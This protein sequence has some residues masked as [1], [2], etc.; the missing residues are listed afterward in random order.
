MRTRKSLLNFATGL[1]GQML[2]LAASLVQRIV[3]T[4]LMSASYLGL[5]GLFSG[6][7]SVLSLAEL[8]VGPAITFSLY[9]PLAQGDTQTVKSLMRLYRRAYRLI[10]CVILALGFL[11]T[12]VYPHLIRDPGTIP[13]LTLIYWLYVVNTGISYFFSYKISLI[14]ADQNQYIRN[15]GHYAAYVLLNLS[16]TV[17]L[18]VTRS[19]VLFLL[20]QIVFTL[21]ENLLLSR[22]ADRRYPY[23]RD[24]DVR[25]L[26]REETAPIVRNIRA[27]LCHNVGNMVVNSTD[28]ILIARILGLA[29]SGVYSNYALILTA[30]RNVLARV[31]DAVQASVGNVWAQGDLPKLRTVYERLFYLAFWLFGVCAIAQ[32]CLIQPCVLLLF[33]EAYLLDNLTV[34]M[35]VASFY[36]TGM[37]SVLYVLRAAA[38]IYYRDWA[39]PL[40]EAAVNLAAS[41]LFLR[42]F[43]TAGV[44]MGT[45]VSS[46]L[47]TGIEA[48]VT[49]RYVLDMR[50]E[51]FF[52]LYA[53]YSLCTAAAGALVWALL[54]RIGG[55]GLGALLLR[56]VLCVAMTGALFA[57]G[58]R[59]SP[60]LAYF[61]DLIRRTAQGLKRRGIPPQHTDGQ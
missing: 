7:L 49:C 40:L 47:A 33:G 11:L 21:A 53:R 27:M 38:G 17:L 44:F 45:L 34:A 16:Q 30:V 23:L 18:V 35:L 46:I 60:E 13:E 1:T 5:S 3:F 50:A 15:I 41:I 61:L 12:P 32:G 22:V 37:R 55:A 54:A 43:G 31:F 57:A 39:K 48:H 52:R 9:K 28:S 58:S 2:A 10:G 14:V 24:R 51:A 25:T 36:V 6:I 29:V 26:K 19:Y 42:R 56:S 20:C 59:K 8:G 4:R